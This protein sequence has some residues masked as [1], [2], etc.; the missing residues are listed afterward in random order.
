[1]SKDTIEDYLL[2]LGKLAV[3]V[4]MLGDEQD[5]FTRHG[6]LTDD[7][8]EMAE[9]IKWGCD[10]LIVTMGDQVRMVGE[11]TPKTWDETI[12]DIK[13]TLKNGTGKESAVLKEDL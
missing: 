1:M 11:R 4:R 3:I 5:N 12:E 6:I 2:V 7:E 9:T 10:K 13:E 8:M